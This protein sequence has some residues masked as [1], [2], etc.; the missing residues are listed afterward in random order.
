MAET[1]INKPEMLT[2][3]Q[4]ARRKVLPERTLRRLVAT[5]KIPVIR[6]GK[7]MYLNYTRLCEQLQSG[8]GEIW[9]QA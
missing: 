4:V 8:E 5:G 2:V 9:Q 3:R 7:T 6:S 1:T